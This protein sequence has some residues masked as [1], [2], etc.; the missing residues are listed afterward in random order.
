M[1]EQE[2][3]IRAKEYTDKLANGID[4]ISGVEM[5]NDTVLNNVRLARYFFYLSGILNELI[6]S[7]K[8]HTGNKKL[9]FAIMRA[10]IDQIALSDDPIPISE[11]AKRINAVIDEDRKK[12]S[13]RWAN[14][15]LIEAGFL[16]VYEAT[17]KKHPTE[18][19]KSLG[20][21][22]EERVSSTSGSYMVTLYRREAQQF[23]LD[24]LDAIL[25]K[26]SV[27]IT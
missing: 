18:S 12:F 27:S 19:G 23:L 22:Q 11:F 21:F 6:S 9:P 7:E 13:Y 5:P 20:I 26:Q 15:W 8:K 17:N 25:A 16:G 3:L 24:N 14:E 2:K 4:P 10:Q 1:A